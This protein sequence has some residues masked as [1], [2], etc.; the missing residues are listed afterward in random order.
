MECDTHESEANEGGLGNGDRSGRFVAQRRWLEDE[1]QVTE[2]GVLLHRLLWMI[3]D[4]TDKLKTETREL[5]EMT[6]KR[7]MF[8]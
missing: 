3:G 2:S 6:N 8:K 5:A 4:S 7:N 1:E